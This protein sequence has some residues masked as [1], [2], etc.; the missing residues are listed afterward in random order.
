MN[1]R[2]RQILI[3]YLNFKHKEIIFSRLKTFTLPKMKK[4]LLNK[5]KTLTKNDKARDKN[6]GMWLKLFSENNLFFECF[7]KIDAIL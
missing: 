1:E 3:K 5:L 4:S 6:L 7:K 2:L